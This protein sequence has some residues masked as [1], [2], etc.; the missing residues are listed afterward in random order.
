MRCL[1]ELMFQVAIR[2]EALALL[3]AYRKG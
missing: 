3:W 1:I 2:I